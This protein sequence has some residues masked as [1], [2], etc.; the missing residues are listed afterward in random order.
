MSSIFFRP[1]APSYMSPNC[2]GR[3]GELRGFSQKVKLCTS[4]DMG[5]PN[6]LTNSIFNLWVPVF[7]GVCKYFSLRMR[8]FVHLNYGYRSVFVIGYCINFS[9]K[10]K[11][12]KQCCGSGMFVPDPD[13]VHIGSNNSNKREG[14][15]ICCLTFFVSHKFDKI[16]NC[17]IFEHLR[18]IKN[19]CLFHPKNWHQAL[20]NMVGGSKGQKGTGTGFRIRIHNTKKA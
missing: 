8:G 6:K 4:R 9:W 1:T 2:G 18:T 3:G 15:Q 14:G 17:F 11:K 5:S 7:S 19:Y 10:L 16:E 13:I 12:K 20:K